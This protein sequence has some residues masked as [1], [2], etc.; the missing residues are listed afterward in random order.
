MRSITTLPV[1]AAA[2][3]LAASATAQEVYILEIG[4]GLAEGISDNGVV[5]GS[6]GAPE[7]F[8][9]SL[10]DGWSLIGGVPAGGGVGG[11]AKIS[12]DGL[13]VCGSTYNAAE[14][15]HEMS[16]YDVAA[17]TWTG[18]GGIGGETDQEIS[19]GWAM[20]GDGQSVAGL[21]WVDAGSAHAAVWNVDTGMTDLGSTV[22]GQSTRANGLNGD[23]S[24][25]VG[26]QDGAGR[27]GA[28]WVDGVQE[29]IFKDGGESALE[30]FAASNDGQWV[31][32]FDVR[33]FVGVAAAYRY[34][35]VTDT[36]EELPNIAGGESRMAG[37]GVTDDGAM[38][39]GGTWGLGPATF[40]TGLIWREGVGTMTFSDFLDELGVPYPDGFVFNFVSDV[41]SDGTWFCGWGTQGGFAA[42]R[43]FVV[44][45]GGDN[46][47]P[48]DLNDDDV[49]DGADLG[50][51]LGNWGNAGM[52][53]LNGDRV[54]DGADLGLLLG[55]WGDC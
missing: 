46:P 4:E 7:Y 43:T 8:M 18:L 34:N 47:C 53:D 15:Y 26:W 17:G 22:E 30:A 16:R 1:A 31:T 20:S 42:N 50:L 2:A 25:V 19:S 11:Q 28:V 40:G 41:S 32:G 48:G 36:Y 23:G 52:G 54:V 45:L 29:L 49:I 27:Q 39:V 51:L 14:D 24:V 6:F 37:T 9:W 5:V 12:N 21:A 35:T 38:I 3:F 13:F 44:H 33:G 10:A 55:D